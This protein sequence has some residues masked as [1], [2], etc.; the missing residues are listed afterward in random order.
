[1]SGDDGNATEKPPSPLPVAVAGAAGGLLAERLGGPGGAVI[2]GA[3]TAYMVEL[4]RKV[5]DEFRPESQ[6][7]QA[8][9]LGQAADAWGGVPEEFDGLIGQSE[10]SRL[11]TATAMA[12]AAATAWPPKVSALG[13]ALADGLIANDDEI[14]IT[15]LVIPAMT[16]MDRAHVSLLE[17]L[18]RWI[19]VNTVTSTPR[20]RPYEEIIAHREAG[21]WT[22]GPRVW[23]AGQIG[24][25][26][27]ALRSALPSLMGTLL[28]HG[29]AAEHDNTAGVLAKYS[30]RMRDEAA[31][32]GPRAGERIKSSTFL[33]KALSELEMGSF[34]SRPSWS[35]TALSERVLGYYEQAGAQ[36]GGDQPESL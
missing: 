26:R 5:W 20:L 6:R 27:P 29:L 16:D 4:A 33:P 9:M 7:R 24:Q 28:R 25:A 15:D 19:P 1:M 12:G 11:L 34:T 10:R 31:R 21:R 22:A 14:S 23:S 17:L 3:A 18:V 30:K 13:R 8:E 35:P 32:H 36:F 2:G